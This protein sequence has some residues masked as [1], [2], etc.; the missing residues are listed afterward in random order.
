M[1]FDQFSQELSALV[2]KWFKYFYQVLKM[3]VYIAIFEYQKETSSL[4]NNTEKVHVYMYNLVVI[5]AM[6][7]T[8]T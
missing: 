2:S 8:I 1:G 6:F 3:L 4:F 5:G 7:F